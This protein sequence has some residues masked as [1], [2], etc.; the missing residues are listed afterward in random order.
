MT[1][2]S[3]PVRIWSGYAPNI[4]P[5]GLS[6]LWFSLVPTQGKKKSPVHG[7][8][9][10]GRNHYHS[11]IYTF[12]E[13]SSQLRKQ[14]VYACVTN[15][16]RRW[17]PAGPRR[18]GSCQFH[19]KGGHKKMGSPFRARKTVRRAALRVRHVSGK[20]TRRRSPVP[21]NETGKSLSERLDGCVLDPLQIG[22]RMW[23]D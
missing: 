22:E 6:S 14:Q 16:A 8:E 7:S 9:G 15:I 19:I 17:K 18:F 12:L 23:I 13:H 5:A 3:I 4:S 10:P 21:H 2:Y 1:T 20:P 11:S